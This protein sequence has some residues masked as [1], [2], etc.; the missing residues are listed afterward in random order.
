MYYMYYNFDRR[1]HM[2]SHMYRMIDIQVHMC[3]G[4]KFDNLFDMYCMIDRLYHM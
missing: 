4:M 3:F 2:L 1:S